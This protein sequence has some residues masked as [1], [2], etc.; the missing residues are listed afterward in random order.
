MAFF[1]SALH[2]TWSYSIAAVS[3]SP[4]DFLSNFQPGGTATV[5]CDNWI[6]RIIDKGED[7]FGLGRWS[8]ITLRGKGSTKITIITAYNASYNLGDTTNYRQQQ[9]T[10]S[11]LHRK[12]NQNIDAQ[13]R[14][15]FILDLQALIGYL[16]ETNHEVILSLDAN[17][18]YDPDASAPTHP[19]LYTP[20]IPTVDKNHNGK[21][22]TLVSTC[23]LLDPLARQ[24]SSRPIPPSHNRGSERI[25]FIFVTPNIMPAVLSSGC[26]SSYCYLIVT[27]EF[28]LWTLTPWY[29]FLIQHT[30]Y[31]A[32]KLGI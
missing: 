31:C 14:R 21:L 1:K 22:A 12:H 8:Y 29:Y 3:R 19:L 5:I 28:I 25:D 7:H 27:T 30:R 2:Q 9:R 13:P 20:G 16:R 4:E 17:T 15:K 26:L 18:S 10:L 6:S 24:H 23:G 11:H 32:P